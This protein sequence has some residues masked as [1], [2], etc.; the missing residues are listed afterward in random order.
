MTRHPTPDTLFADPQLVPGD[1][2]ALDRV[3]D[4]TLTGREGRRPG[5]HFEKHNASQGAS[6]QSVK[7]HEIHR[8]TEEAG[9]LGVIAEAGQVRHEL[10]GD[11]P[12]RD[13]QTPRHRV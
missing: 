2:A 5:L 13:R 6:V 11:F 1:A 9:V 8:T 10:L 7:H 4:L 3:A 12:Y